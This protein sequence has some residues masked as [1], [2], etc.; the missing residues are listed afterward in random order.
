MENKEIN[1]Q[2]TDNQIGAYQDVLQKEK[3]SCGFNLAS[4]LLPEDYQRKTL[5]SFVPQNE[6]QEE[7]KRIVSRFIDDPAG[8]SIFLYGPPGTGKTHLAAAVVLELAYKN[9]QF[10]PFIDCESEMM[11]T[12]QGKEFYQFRGN[13]NYIQFQKQAVSIFDDLSSNS[14]KTLSIT[15]ESFEKDDTQHSGIRRVNHVDNL[16]LIGKAILSDDVPSWTQLVITWLRDNSKKDKSE[17]SFFVTSNANPLETIVDMFHGAVYPEKNAKRIIS[18][19]SQ[20]TAFIKIEGDDF[21]L[22]NPWYSDY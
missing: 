18:R 17:K 16:H 22:R 10:V 5:A 1:N 19:I 8:K 3:D 9:R 21:R 7:A 13:Q 12:P 2:I 11:C 6:N 20:Q 15:Y 14:S 4:C